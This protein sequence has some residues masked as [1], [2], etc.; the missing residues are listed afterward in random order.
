M[1][2]REV[3]TRVRAEPPGRQDQPVHGVTSGHAS[4]HRTAQSGGRIKS[5][6][7]SAGAAAPL[8]GLSGWPARRLL[9]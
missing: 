6:L 9:A 7:R 4:G 1:T 8:S 5:L 2:W 3:P